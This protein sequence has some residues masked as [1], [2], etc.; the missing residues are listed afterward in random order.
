MYLLNLM[1][2]QCVL[3]SSC[4]FSNLWQSRKI[5]DDIC[6]RKGSGLK[7]GRKRDQAFPE[8]SHFV[9]PNRYRIFPKFHLTYSLTPEKSCVKISRKKGQRHVLI[10][11]LNRGTIFGKKREICGKSSEKI[12][13]NGDRLFWEQKGLGIQ[14]EKRER[15]KTGLLLRIGYI[16]NLKF[17]LTKW[18]LQNKSL[19]FWHRLGFNFV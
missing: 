14:I 1:L 11:V 5:E 3:A 4:N 16:I 15:E 2:Q 17:R 8:F 10:C 13:E 12:Q 7:I 18:E 9:F 19:A 6:E